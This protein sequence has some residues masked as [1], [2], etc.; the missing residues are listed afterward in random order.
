MPSRLFWFSY[1][2]DQYTTIIVTAGGVMTTIVNR[3]M[4]IPY[5]QTQTFTT[6]SENQPGV[7]F[8]YMKVTVL[9]PRIIFYL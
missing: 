2:L 9:S 8:R 4:T 6:Y 3:N 7:L 5:K 1:C